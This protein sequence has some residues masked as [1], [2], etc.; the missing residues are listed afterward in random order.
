MPPTDGYV[1]RL[2]RL[3]NAVHK[4]HPAKLVQPFLRITAVL[5]LASSPAIPRRGAGRRTTAAIPPLHNPDVDQARIAHVHAVLAAARPHPRR[6]ARRVEPHVLAAHD[7]HQEVVVGVRVQRRDGPGGA[8]PGVDEWGN[9]IM[10]VGANSAILFGPDGECVGRYRKTNLFETDTTW[11]KPGTGFVTFHLPPPLNSVSLGIC[12][13]INTQK[14]FDWRSVKGPYELASHC[15]AENSNLLILLNAWLESPEDIGEDHAWTTL[16]F[17][18]GR[19]RPLWEQRK[20][21]SANDHRETNVV[22]CNRTGHENGKKF[23]GSSCSFQMNNSFGK[24]RLR[25]VMG[26]DEEGISVWTV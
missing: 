21:T 8:E 6:L 5:L 14:P 9:D 1:K 4:R 22:I 18:A 26:K 17:W 11:A 2:P 7:L 19:L 16:N 20:G 23:C 15:V 12:K 10:R 25:H 3:E 24:P 13:D